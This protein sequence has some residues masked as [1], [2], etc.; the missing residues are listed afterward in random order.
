MIICSKLLIFLEKRLVNFG[1]WSRWYLD[2]I[3]SQDS[4]NYDNFPKI[5]VFSKKIIQNVL[6]SISRRYINEHDII[7]ENLNK[8]HP[9]INLTIEVNPCRF[10]DTK[11]INNKSN[12]KTYVFRKISKLPLH[13]SPRVPK[14]YKQNAEFPVTSK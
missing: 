10:L 14:R 9:K 8:Y 11:I 6:Q 13:W 1:K 12:I 4:K 5:S 7:F 2:L 3:F